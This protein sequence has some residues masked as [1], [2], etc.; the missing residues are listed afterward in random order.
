M[1]TAKKIMVKLKPRFGKRVVL[2]TP[3]TDIVLTDEVGEVDSNIYERIKDYVDVIPTKEK[4][5]EK[6]TEFFTKD[7][8]T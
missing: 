5:R 4:R 8:E 3:S 2:C 6:K 1:T 7:E